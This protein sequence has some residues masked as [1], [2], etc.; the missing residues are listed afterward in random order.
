[1][2]LQ[3]SGKITHADI[4]AEY[5]LGTPIKLTNYYDAA[6]GIPAAGTIKES[7]F[8]GTSSYVPPMIIQGP[9]LSGY[10]YTSGT[11]GHGIAIGYGGEVRFQYRKGASAKCD[12]ISV[13]PY[14][15][16]FHFKIRDYLNDKGHGTKFDGHKIRWFWG[17]SFCSDDKNSSCTSNA[18]SGNGSSGYINS[19]G[20]QRQVIGTYDVSGYWS[21]A[22]GPRQK[23]GQTST[24][25]NQ[26]NGVGEVH[27]TGVVADY[28]NNL[29]VYIKNTTNF[30]S[31]RGKFTDDL[32]GLGLELYK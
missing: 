10:S 14:T 31:I 27:A 24:Y 18:T 29:R 21:G 8:Y 2:T 9:E 3:T 6:T 1:M 17:T 5:Q 7:D 16:Y 12:N 20:S 15:V 13:A 22:G 11:A 32:R 28:G 4:E 25:G 30:R 26:S 19:G 23:S